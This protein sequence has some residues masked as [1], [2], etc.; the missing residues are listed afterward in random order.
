MGTAADDGA[1]ARRALPPSDVSTAASSTVPQV[2]HSG[3]RPTHL[4]M[5]CSHWVQRY[6]ARCFTGALVDLLTRVTVSAGSDR[7]R[8][9]RYWSG[10]RCRA[11]R[12][13]T[14]RG[15]ERVPLRRGSVQLTSAEE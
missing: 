7:H 11:R 3:Q 8:Q 6:C 2:P 13:L 4:A 12:A 5:T 14:M 9:A 15:E 10:R 1:I